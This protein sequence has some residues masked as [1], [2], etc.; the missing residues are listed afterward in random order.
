MHRGGNNPTSYLCVDGQYEAVFS[1]VRHAHTRSMKQTTR[2]FADL[3]LSAR[4]MYSD[5]VGCVLLYMKVKKTSEF[6]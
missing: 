1:S 3:V 5:K 2:C 4:I 6:Y